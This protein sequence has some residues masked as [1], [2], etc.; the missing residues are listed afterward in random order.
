MDNDTL[1][2]VGV[3]RVSVLTFRDRHGRMEAITSVLADSAAHAKN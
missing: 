3:T 2:S 1:R